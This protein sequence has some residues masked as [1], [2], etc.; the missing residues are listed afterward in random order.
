MNSKTEDTRIV[1]GVRCTWWDSIDKTARTPPGRSGHRIPCCPHCGSVLFEYPTEA[2]WFEAADHYEH[3]RPQPGYRK[4]IEWA[5]G[6]CFKS[7]AA[8]K[9]AMDAEQPKPPG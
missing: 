4:L 1:C 8:A 9:I 5:R 6:K 7:M 2:A 3:E